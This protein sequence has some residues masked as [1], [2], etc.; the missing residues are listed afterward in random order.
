M[1]NVLDKLRKLFDE[2]QRILKLQEDADKDKN[3]PISYSATLEH[4][5]LK[6]RQKLNSEGVA[7]LIQYVI[8]M[9]AKKEPKQWWTKHL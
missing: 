9:E 1:N 8:E 3:S 5:F 2:E 4:A 7:L 6:H